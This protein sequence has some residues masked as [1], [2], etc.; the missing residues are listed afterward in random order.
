VY[1]Y[2]HEENQVSRD[3]SRYELAQIITK[4]LEASEM[5]IEPLT[6]ILSQISGQ[7]QEIKEILEPQEQEELTFAEEKLTNISENLE[8]FLEEFLQTPDN[9][10]ILFDDEPLLY[11]ISTLHSSLETLTT[12]ISETSETLADSM[13]IVELSSLSTYIFL[14]GIM[15]AAFILY[16]IYK[17]MKQF[18][19]FYR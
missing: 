17:I 2:G 12:S 16:F 1:D 9:E 15:P 8:K 18:V 6:Y 4:Q 11:S 3:I 7:L 19:M 14:I 10:P 13:Q 5:D